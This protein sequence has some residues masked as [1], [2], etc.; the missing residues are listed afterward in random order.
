MMFP[1]KL[2]L[3]H[4][5]LPVSMITNENCQYLSFLAGMAKT[6][7]RSSMKCEDRVRLR[8]VGLAKA[9]VIWVHNPN[10]AIPMATMNLVGKK[11]DCP[12]R[13]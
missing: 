1:V 10:Q 6:A 5:H 11:R 9:V 8:T 13:Q 12:I 7:I 3:I 2:R 4:A